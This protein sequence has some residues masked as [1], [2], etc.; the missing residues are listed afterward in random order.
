MPELTQIT[1]RMLEISNRLEQASRVIHKMASEKAEKERIY[2]MRL[3]QEILKLKAEGM[4]ATLIPDVARGNLS[5]LLFERDASEA[6]F[7]AALEAL[8]ALK[9]QL[10]ALQ[11]ILKYL[12]A[13]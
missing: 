9:S 8:E 4:S 6:R 5:D 2:R 3:A 11:S 13:S 10:S 12:E 7:K 1:D